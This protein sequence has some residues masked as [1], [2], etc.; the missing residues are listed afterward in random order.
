MQ[1]AFPIVFA[2]IVVVML[3]RTATKRRYMSNEEWQKLEERKQQRVHGIVKYDNNKKYA[4]DELIS[5]VMSYG[6]RTASSEYIMLRVEALMKK[7]R[8]GENKFIVFG[9]LW[10][11]FSVGF[12]AIFIFSSLASVEDREISMFGFLLLPLAFIGVGFALTGGMVWKKISVKKKS[13]MLQSG[14]YTAYTLDVTQKMWYESSGED[15]TYYYYVKCGDIV[16]RIDEKEYEDV[17]DKV[18]VFVFNFPKGEA[19]EIIS[20]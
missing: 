1:F 4:S 9:I 18:M 6:Q 15:T 16:L 5:R 7:Q 8:R 13:A 10:T 14:D 12:L 3:V 17:K 19:I 20:G 2:V 11:L